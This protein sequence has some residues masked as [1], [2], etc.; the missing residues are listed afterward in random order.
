[1]PFTSKGEYIAFC[2]DD[3]IWLPEKLEKQIKVFQ[4]SNET[5]MVYTRFRTIEEDIIS[6]RIFPKNGKYKSGDIFKALY[7]WRFIACSSVMD[8]RSVLDQVGLFDTDPDLIAIEDTDLWLRIALKHI[9]KCTD[10]SP[11]FL[12]RIQ[13]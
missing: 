2:D 8:K 3:D 11:L 6:N 13:P 5:A 7:I 4:I 12:Y 1:M 10:N 9:I